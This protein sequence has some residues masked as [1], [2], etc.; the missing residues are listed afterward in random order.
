MR[1]KYI[2]NIRWITVVL[3][4]IY[5]VIYMYNSVETAGVIGTICDVR[6]QDSFQYIV[7]PWFM[8]LLFTISGM[9]ARYYLNNHTDKEF[10]HSRTTKLLVPSTIG[11]VVFHW[12]LGYYNM[13]IAGAFEMMCGVPKPVLAL[14]IIISG[15]GALWYLQMLWIFSMILIWIRKIEK[16]RFYRLCRETNVIVLI[17]LTLLVVVSAKVLNAPVIVVYRFGIYSVGFFIGYFCL[18]YDEVVDRLEKYWYV[19][20]T[21]GIILAVVFVKTNFGK[22]YAE[23]VVLDTPLCSTYGWI[24]TLAVIAFMKR[25]G[26]WESPFSRWMIRKSWGLYIFHYPVLAA[27][28]YYLNL[29]G[30]GIPA[31]FIYILSAVAA[32]GGAYVLD[33]VISRVP[34]FRWAVL[35]I[36]R[37]KK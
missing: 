22:P 17:M 2:D 10:V 16:E 4:V 36:R 3:V 8:L 24:A 28:A 11:L 32:F 30:K 23:H 5:H 37:R 7:Y 9:S 29:Y 12:I 33:E 35:G 14:L 34:F 26:E 31:F 18:S 25:W 1:K 27:C 15:T 21:A 6:Y 19:F 13:Q 20:T